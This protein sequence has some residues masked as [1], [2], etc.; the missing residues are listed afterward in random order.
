[1]G[2]GLNL[3]LIVPVVH[4]AAVFSMFVVLFL[5]FYV[6]TTLV[7]LSVASFVLSSFLST[8]LSV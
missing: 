5:L 6:K 3:P 1:M 2:N 4:C 8:V 7:D